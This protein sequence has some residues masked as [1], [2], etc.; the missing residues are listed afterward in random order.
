M[1][2]DPKA[3]AN[4]FLDLA[5]AQEKALTPLK[6]QKL[7]YFANGW[8]LAIKGVPLINEQVEAWRFGPVIPSLYTH[9]ERM[10][11]VR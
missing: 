4:Y 6:I 11:N 10:G 7:V 8:H 9:F 1:P 3:I 2:Y 5:R